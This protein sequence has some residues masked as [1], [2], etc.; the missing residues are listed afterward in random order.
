MNRLEELEI[1]LETMAAESRITEAKLEE[2]LADK[3][4]IQDKIHELC[5]SIEGPEIK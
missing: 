2:A 4:L 1:K 5:R 3:Q